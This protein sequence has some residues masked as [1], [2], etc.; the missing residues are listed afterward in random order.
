MKTELDGLE[1]GGTQLLRGTN[2][3]TAL[4]STGKW[5]AGTWRRASA[6]SDSTGNTRTS[7]VVNDAPNANIKVGWEIKRNGTS[8]IDIAQDAVPVTVGQTYTL[9]CYAKGTGAIRL[10]YGK[11]PYPSKQYTLSNVT[12]WTRY[13]Y[14]FTIG[15]KS[16]GST[17]GSTNI[18]I[19]AGANGTIQICGQK[20]ETGNKAHDWSP[21]PEDWQKQI[22]GKANASHGRHVPAACE[23]ITDW[24]AATTTGWYMG[25]GAA[26][27]PTSGSVWYFGRVIAHN[28]NYLLQEVWQFTASTDAKAIPHYIRAK[29]NGTWGAWTNVTVSK[30]VPA[31]AVFT[32]TNTWR[33]IQNN[34]TSD[35]VTDSL[36]AKQGKILKGLVDGKSVIKALTNE[37]LNDVTV[38]GF[39]NSG[40]GNTVTNKPSG[41][42]PFGL[43]VI[44]NV[45][46]AYYTQIIF[47]GGYSYRRH[48]LNNTWGAW[49]T[50]KLTDTVYTVFKA[51]TADA[52]GGTGLVPQP[53]KGAQ[54]KYLRGDGTWQTPPNTTYNNMSG[55]T[56]SAAG[57][58]GLVPAPAAGAN[59]KYLRGD[60]TWQTP[61]DTN[62]TYGSMTGATASAAGKSGLVPVP[63]AGAQAKYLR[64]DGTWQTPPNTTYSAFKAATASAAGG[65][66]LV[67][68]PAAGAQAKYLRADGMWQTPPN[69]TYGAAT[70]SATGLMSAAD[71]KK[72]DGMENPKS[73][74]V[75]IP[76]SG[77]GSDSDP[78]Y[79]KYYDIAVSGITANDRA[80]IDFP[81]S[82]EA[83]VK[84]CGMWHTNQT[85][86]GKI[87]IRAKKVPTAAISAQYWVEKGK[88]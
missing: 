54:A 36:S 63:V 23:T 17:D 32:D 42:D 62:T 5:S 12:R 18:Y 22:D 64:G 11:N 19:G 7:I 56:G 33:G 68:A 84:A 38:P 13:S 86:A 77:W 73:T 30:A 72:L 57:K 79:P 9:S 59:T 4:T 70:Q 76:T 26:N 21:A 85:L 29:M 49:A 28:T 74:A 10:Q 34:L 6:A 60:G 27:A 20:L 50:D 8:S 58:S 3:V 65:A 82:S 52:A 87:R 47:S 88:G 81:M 51:A 31:N 66:G 55:A 71:K 48:C 53:A 40:G 41:V 44:H 39:Y 43:I 1:V 67:P 25:A 83:L 14:T 16:D 46:G 75:T 69:T 78:D 15:E 2:T 61:P 35:S 24:N 45:S 80:S 37:D